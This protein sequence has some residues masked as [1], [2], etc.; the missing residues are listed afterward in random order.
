MT[1]LRQTATANELGVAEFFSP[2][3]RQSV[4]H[5]IES[6]AEFP[7]QILTFDVPGAPQDNVIE[8]PEAAVVVAFPAHA[9]GLRTLVRCPAGAA[10]ADIALE[11]RY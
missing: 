5:R 3:N 11:W 6:P 10:G 9:L 7:A 1:I 2:V 4:V 8:R